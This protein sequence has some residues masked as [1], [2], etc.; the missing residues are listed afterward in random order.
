[1]PL[2]DLVTNLMRMDLKVINEERFLK[3]ALDMP[4]LTPNQPALY[5]YLRAVYLLVLQEQFA[6][7]VKRNREAKNSVGA[8]FG[9]LSDLEDKLF[10]QKF[11]QKPNNTNSDLLK[12]ETKESDKSFA[13]FK[14]KEEPKV[15]EAE[16]KEESTVLTSDEMSSQGNAQES[17]QDNNTTVKTDTLNKNNSQQEASTSQQESSADNNDANASK[18]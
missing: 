2:V 7:S 10:R 15:A 18:T 14:T 5:N 17:V 8:D 11:M 4:P 9:K 12:V 1:M 3:F 16:N 6:I 13:T